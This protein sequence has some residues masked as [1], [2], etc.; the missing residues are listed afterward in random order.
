MFQ[1]LTLS[2]NP[3]A[4]IAEAAPHAPYLSRLAQTVEGIADYKSLFDR[5]LSLCGSLH[6]SQEDP[7]ITLRRAKQMAHLAIA[8]GDLSGEASLAKTTERITRFADAALDA[9]FGYTLRQAGL[10]S[11]GLFAIAL[12]KMGAF[13]L[14][15]S[16]DIDI[17]VFFDPEIF[18]GGDREPG[19]AAIRATRGAVSLL[20]DRTPDGYVFRTDLRLRPDPSSTPVAV[21][22]RRAELYYESVGQ[23]WERMVWIKGRGCAGDLEAADNFL[24]ALEPLSGAGIWTIG[25]LAMSM[26]SRT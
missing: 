8:A 22:T 17:A 25:R 21:S 19:D 20:N 6:T 15:Y 18:K 9:A 3:E 2:D 23:N 1:I 4:A 11:A 10:E 24:K 7:Y 5:A 14:N 12:G 13:E 16:S 26:P